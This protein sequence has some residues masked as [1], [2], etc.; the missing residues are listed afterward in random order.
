M[1]EDLLARIRNGQSLSFSQKMKLVITLSMPAIMAQLTSIIM[2]YIDAAMVGRLGANASAAIGVVAS[3]TWLFSGLCMAAIAGFSIQAAH[4]IGAKEF[5]KAKEVLGHSLLVV[6]GVGLVMAAIG[7]A[8]SGQLP[9]RLGSDVEIRQDASAYF[10][11]F[12][13]SLPMVALNRLAASMLQCS[14]NMK[15]PG[16][17]NSLMCI[18]DIVLNA[19]FIYGMELGVLGAA[20]GTAMSEVITAGF[21]LYFLLKKTPMLHMDKGVR[22]RLQPMYLSR[23]LKLSLPIAC[24]RCIMSGALVLTTGMVAPLGAVATASNSLAVTAESLCYM[25]GFG[26]GEAATTLIGQSM[27]ARRKDMIRSF[28]R[29]TVV[30]AMIFMAATAVLLYVFAPILM[31]ILSPDLEVQQLGAGILRI[32]AF[33]EPLYGASIVISGVLR[34]AGDTLMC[35]VLS[36]V[37]LWC[38]RIPLSYLLVKPLGLIGIWIAMCTELCFRGTIFIVRLVRGKWMRRVVE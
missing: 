17:L 25:P 22:F 6:L 20:L 13:C 14:G 32:E 26:I 5:Q 8:I 35:S 21:M 9:L 37:S 3:S 18:W 15:V 24:E 28:S 36:L 10:L 27:G 12:A 31:G 33:A 1:Q 4:F 29:I 7:A 30:F 16:I 2:Q 34:G 11:V 38:V 19:V 23:A